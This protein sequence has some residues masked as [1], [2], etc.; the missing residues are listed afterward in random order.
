[1]HAMSI[2]QELVRERA[3]PCRLPS[4]LSSG[5][6]TAPSRAK[7][8]AAGVLWQQRVALLAT[9]NRGELGVALARLKLRCPQEPSEPAAESTSDG[10]LAAAAWPSSACSAGPPAAIDRGRAALVPPGG[11]VAT[12]QPSPPSPVSATVIRDRAIIGDVE[13]SAPADGSA[14]GSP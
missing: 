3:P 1:M 2:L 13:G 4:A 7:E 8:P 12:E 9:H 6:R 11:G 14:N 10:D 5:S